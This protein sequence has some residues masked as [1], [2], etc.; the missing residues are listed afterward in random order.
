M[1]KEKSDAS[2]K[3]LFGQKV[4]K[5]VSKHQAVQISQQLPFL[6]AYKNLPLTTLSIPW[7]RWSEVKHASFPRLHRMCSNF[8]TKILLTPQVRME[9]STMKTWLSSYPLRM[10]RSSSHLHTLLP[11]WENGQFTWGR[12]MRD[13]DIF[14]IDKC[15]CWLKISNLQAVVSL[16]TIDLWTFQ[17]SHFLKTHWEESFAAS[18]E[19]RE[20]HS[21]F[22]KITLTTPGTNH[23]IS[24]G[25]L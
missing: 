2:R 24:C 22:K 10:Q 23:G 3:V 16:A 6:P 14:R 25:P 5:E 17:V 4:I 7:L 1:K 9:Y 18:F 13:A 11:R 12:I 21:T 20:F 19:F 8:W 15:I